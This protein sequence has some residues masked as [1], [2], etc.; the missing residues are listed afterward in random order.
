MEPV[1]AN[2]SQWK[3]MGPLE[4]GKDC[5]LSFFNLKNPYPRFFL[6]IESSLDLIFVFLNFNV[7]PIKYN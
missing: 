1:E 3:P 7:G 5:S 6:H 4:K 2:G